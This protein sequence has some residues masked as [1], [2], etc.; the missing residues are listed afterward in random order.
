[1]VLS[2]I[3]STMLNWLVLTGINETWAVFT[4]SDVLL[5]FLGG[6]GLASIFVVMIVALSKIESDE[7]KSK[8]TRSSLD[9]DERVLDNK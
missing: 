9:P 2:M 1:M 3:D 8:S 6:A 7:K 5:S 4:K